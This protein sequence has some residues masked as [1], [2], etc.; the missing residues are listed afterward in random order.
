MRFL[1]EQGTARIRWRR[2]LDRCKIV[3]HRYPARPKCAV[4]NHQRLPM[5]LPALPSDLPAELPVGSAVRTDT[6]VCGPQSGPYSLPLLCR[7]HLVGVVLVLLS[8]G[9]APAQQRAPDPADK[10]TKIGAMIAM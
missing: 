1:E 9:T 4:T 2:P 10:F 3:P 6:K 7:R 5:Q 8:G